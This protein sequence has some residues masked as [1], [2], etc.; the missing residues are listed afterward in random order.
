MAKKLLR[1]MLQGYLDLRSAQEPKRAHIIGGDGVKRPHRRRPEVI[2]GLEED[3][4][5]S[6]PRA[7]NKRVRASVERDPGKVTEELFEEVH[8]R[9][10]EHKR[11][12]VMLV[13]GH[14]KLF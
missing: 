4:P 6:R 10:P 12:W 2:M 9:D 5:S 8:R 13:D 1:R 3:P 7:R 14:K 11:P